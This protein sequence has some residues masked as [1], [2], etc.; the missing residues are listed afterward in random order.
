MSINPNIN[1][2]RKDRKTLVMT[3]MAIALL[4]KVADRQ[5]DKTTRRFNQLKAAIRYLK[6]T[7]KTFPGRTGDYFLGKMREVTDEL[8]Q[9]LSSL[10]AIIENEHADMTA[11]E[12]NDFA[13]L[14]VTELLICKALERLSPCAYHYKQ[15]KEN[16]HSAHCRIQLIDESYP[17]DPGET[18]LGHIETL[19]DGI[20]A[21]LDTLC[22]N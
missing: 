3:A 6:R 7:D 18:Y 11:Q 12:R 22:D 4:E 1:L 21:D 15:R 5:T 16:L 2:T 17:G 9:D 10:Q 20:D 14:V 13:L 8:D 19:A